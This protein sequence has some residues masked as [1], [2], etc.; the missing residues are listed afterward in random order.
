[1]W[2]IAFYHRSMSCLI[3]FLCGHWQWVTTIVVA[4]P[5]AW[6][7]V[8]HFILLKPQ[9]TLTIFSDKG[10]TP[11]EKTYRLKISSHK[12]KVIGRL[13]YRRK[14]IRECQVRATFVFTGRE[15]K[16]C[17]ARYDDGLSATLYPNGRPFIFDLVTKRQGYSQ[18]NIGAWVG[19]ASY[20]L[21]AN[22]TFNVLIDVIDGRIIIKQSKWL[23]HN[24][25]TNLFDLNVV[26]EK[27]N[28]DARTSSEFL[29]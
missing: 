3:A 27:S 15:V 4:L 13:F 9:L 7:V 12:P 24:H 23:I 11:S 5:G 25:G 26:G 20:N 29:S 6:F 17:L 2:C 19:D 8:R 21:P 28:D 16:K 1:M 22:T 18:C 14:Q 10:M